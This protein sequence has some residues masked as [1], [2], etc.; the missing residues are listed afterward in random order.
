[1]DVTFSGEIIMDF[2]IQEVLV[3][4]R[5]K[6]IQQ[7]DDREIIIRVLLLLQQMIMRIM[8]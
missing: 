7:K 1:M 6:W 8:Q 2:Q 5:I 4:V 3:R